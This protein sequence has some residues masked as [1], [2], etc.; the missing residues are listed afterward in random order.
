MKTNEPIIKA[1]LRKN[2]T[3]ADGTHPIMLRIS[4]HGRSEISTGYSCK[5]SQWNEA[6]STVKTKVQNSRTINA[7][8]TALI[9]KAREASYRLEN[10]GVAYTSADIVR[11]M[12]EHRGQKIPQTVED[13][14]QAYIASRNLKVNTVR[15]YAQIVR[16][17]VKYCGGGALQQIS[18]IALAQSLEATGM[19]TY[20]IYQHLAYLRSLS[21]FAQDELMLDGCDIFKRC[22]NLINKYNKRPGKK[23]YIPK[24]SYPFLE[25]VFIERTLTI[26]MPDDNGHFW[27]SDEAELRLRQYT[28]RLFSLFVFILSY[29]LQG[30]APVDLCL[31]K[32]DM[33]KYLVIDGTEYIRIDTKRRKTGANVSIMLDT[34]KTINR[35]LLDILDHFGGQVYLLPVLDDKVEITDDYLRRKV[36]SLSNGGTRYFDEWIA[37]ANRKIEDYNAN[38]FEHIPLIDPRCSLYT[39]RHS[40]ASNYSSSPKSSLTALATLLGRQTRGL[41]TY[42]SQLHS[43]SELVNA[44]GMLDDTDVFGI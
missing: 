27:Y 3:L 14:H 39:A 6:T 44:I 2:K 36:A 4:W 40:F 31:L 30:L 25:Q 43:D 29:R 15:G 37:L 41:D 22:R 10:T 17:I 5:P 18:P 32:R 11:C 21:L 9:E 23:I 35:L 20:P 16:N 34:S 26:I 33:M 13:I 28:S 38:Y 19:R 42:I 8:I 24:E 1:V 12:N 7:T